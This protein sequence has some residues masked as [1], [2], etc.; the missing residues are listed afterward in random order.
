MCFEKRI[1]EQLNKQT[2][3]LLLTDAIKQIEKLQTALKDMNHKHEEAISM[4]EDQIGELIDKHQTMWEEMQ[5][6]D[7]E[8]QRKNEIIEKQNNLI[9]QSEKVK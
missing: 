8:M 1:I 2:K 5:R 4:L 9:K 7:E 3:S 6:K